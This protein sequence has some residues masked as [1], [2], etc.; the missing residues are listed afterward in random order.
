MPRR[1][2]NSNGQTGKKNKYDTSVTAFKKK[3][4]VPNVDLQ[5]IDTMFGNRR[6]WKAPTPQVK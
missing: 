5:T 6:T 1:N 3:R 2:K 4:L